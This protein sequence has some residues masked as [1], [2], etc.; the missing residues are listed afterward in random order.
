MCGL[1]PVPV[2]VVDGIR[3]GGQRERGG[4]I[5][6]EELDAEPLGEGDGQHRECAALPCESDVPIRELE[7]GDI[8]T[9]CHAPPVTPAIASESR[10]RP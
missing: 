4:K 8:V 7:P 2:A 10:P 9:H 6:H 1:R 5:P 3:L